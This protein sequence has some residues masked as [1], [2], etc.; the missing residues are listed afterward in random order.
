MNLKE[1]LLKKQEQ[2]KNSL[3][4]SKEEKLLVFLLL[5]YKSN[6]K[7]TYINHGEGAKLLFDWLD[8]EN[9]PPYKEI[10]LGLAIGDQY[11]LYNIL[12]LHPATVYRILENFRLQKIEKSSKIQEIEIPSPNTL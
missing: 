7:D 2:K 10:P 11:L 1:I 8:V 4:Y 3:P 6:A 12:G 5:Y 9:I